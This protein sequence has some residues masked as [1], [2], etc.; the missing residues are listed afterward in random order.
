MKSL[1]DTCHSLLR[2]PSFKA[3][4]YLITNRE[5]LEFVNDGGYENSKYWTQEGEIS[6]FFVLMCETKQINVAKID[7]MLGKYFICTLICT[8][9]SCTWWLSCVYSKDTQL[10]FLKHV[11]ANYFW[12]VFCHRGHVCD[13]L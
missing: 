12:A 4:K 8:W 2:V 13:I 7:V 1:C 3:S 6:L 10:D 11:F 9:V 5:Y